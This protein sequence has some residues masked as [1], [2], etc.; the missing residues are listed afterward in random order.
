LQIRNILRR[1]LYGYFNSPVAYIFLVVFLMMSGWFTFSMGNFY[2]AR[3]ADLRPFFYF[4]PIIYLIFIPAIAMRLWSEE[5]MTG[6]IQL[7]L[8]LPVTIKDVVIGKFLAAWIF[9]GIALLL[10]FPM[11]LTVGYLGSPDYG[12]I[13][14]SYLGSF[15]MAGAYLAIGSFTSSLTK[16][17]V[18]SFVLSIVF[19]LVLLLMS[20]PMVTDYFAN[21]FGPE[22]VDIIASFGFWVHFESIQ[23]GVIDLGDIFYFLSVIIFMLT[24]NAVVIEVKKAS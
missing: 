19:C 24:A 21:F 7:L 22:T 1:E 3:Q 15:L 4:H 11:I 13:I 2:E 14:A 17:Q 8:T 16:N 5:R 23:R 18:I 20:F 6:T 9:M 12:V 10:T